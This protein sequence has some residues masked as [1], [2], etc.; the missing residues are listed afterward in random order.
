MEVLDVLGDPVR[1]RIVEALSSGSLTSGAIA[2]RFEIS[3]PAISQHL[4]A[5]LAAGV[6]T[7][8]PEGTRR[9]YTLNPDALDTAT[10]WLEQQ[11]VRWN[12][13]LDALEH[14]LDTGQI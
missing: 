3:R 11:R 4:R 5:L 1:R 14:A 6:V 12:R 2:A 8:R 7:V 13:G 10:D 9:V